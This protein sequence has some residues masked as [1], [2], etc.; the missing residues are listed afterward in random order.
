MSGKKNDGPSW[1]GVIVFLAVVIAVGV[2]IY[3]PR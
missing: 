2:Y 3:W 1:F